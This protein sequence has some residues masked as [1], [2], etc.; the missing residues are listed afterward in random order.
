W[1][2]VPSIVG[3]LG[4]IDAGSPT[5]VDPRTLTG[6]NLGAADVIANQGT[7]ILNSATAQGGVAE[8]DGIANPTIAVNGAGTAD[9]P[10]DVLY[11]V[12][13]GRQDVRVQF[14]VRDLDSTTDNSA[15]QVNVQ[16]RIGDSGS[17]TNVTGGYI[18]DATTGPSLAT[19]VTPIDVHLPSLADGQAQVEV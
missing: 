11:L 14:N 9:A 18:S 10:G 5:G 15:Q 13:T 16:Y 6:S 4:D 1:S 8:I 3:Y 2:G 19:L 12:G 17:W 7:T